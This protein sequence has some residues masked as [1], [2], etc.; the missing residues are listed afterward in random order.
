VK[1]EKSEKGQYGKFKSVGRVGGKEVGTEYVE[2]LKLMQ[3]ENMSKLRKQNQKSMLD[4]NL[5]MIGYTSDIMERISRNTSNL[6][7]FDRH[8]ALAKNK[9]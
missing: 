2:Q 6:S 3:R 8:T 9:E 4:I 1:A 5:K 7:Q